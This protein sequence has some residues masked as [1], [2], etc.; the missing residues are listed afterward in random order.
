MIP[1]SPER[2]RQLVLAAFEVML[3]TQAANGAHLAADL[4]WLLEGGPEHL[5]DYVDLRYVSRY[6]IAA[7][8][9]HEDAELPARFTGVNR[10]QRLSRARAYLAGAPDPYGSSIPEQ[11][12]K[13][14]L[15]YPSQDPVRKTVDAILAEQLVHTISKK[16]IAS[17]CAVTPW[18]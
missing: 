3:R 10:D 4:V 16:S 15:L 18:S 9:A 13:N 2:Q 11:L 17:S 8:L 6:M 12:S 7:T 14:L 1:P 5:H